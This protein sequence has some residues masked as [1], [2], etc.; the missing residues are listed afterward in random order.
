MEH[1]AGAHPANPPH[2]KPP[3]R[4]RCRTGPRP[5]MYVTQCLR[6]LRQACVGHARSEKPRRREVTGEFHDSGTENGGPDVSAA[7]RYRRWSALED[8][9]LREMITSHTVDEIAARLDRRSRTAVWNRVRYL[10]LSHLLSG[11]SPR[12]APEED[13]VLRE[14]C[15]RATLEAIAD[16]LP[17]RT[18]S[19]VFNRMKKLGMSN[20]LRGEAHW[21]AKFTN[22]QAMAVG[23]LGD[24]GFTSREIEQLLAHA[25]P[26]SRTQIHYITSGRGRSSLREAEHLAEARKQE[27][28]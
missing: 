9:V 7:N 26:M 25:Q 8:R 21:Q 12:W 5:V 4:T 11:R 13:K 24:A 6:C 18:K 2:R 3:S 10:N 23:V 27:A 22:L 1:G 17:G 28:V 15:G 14:L 16:Q 20:Q 19:A